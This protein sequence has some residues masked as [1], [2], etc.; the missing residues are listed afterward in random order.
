MFGFIV[1]WIISWSILSQLYHQR[2]EVMRLA[3]G[4]AMPFALFG[5]IVMSSIIE[6]HE[7]IARKDL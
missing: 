3:V 4:L 6:Y 2:P 7:K 5:C 1:F